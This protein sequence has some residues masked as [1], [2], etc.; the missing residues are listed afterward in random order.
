M[1][2]NPN[3]SDWQELGFVA[4]H[5]A[6]LKRRAWRPHNWDQAADFAWTIFSD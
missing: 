3:G 2:G 5:L 6:L 1:L 4:D